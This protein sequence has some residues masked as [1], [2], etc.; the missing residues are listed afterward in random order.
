VFLALV[1]A[2][3][4]GNASAGNSPLG[5]VDTTTF[6]NTRV[7]NP[8]PV[9][10]PRH[11]ASPT[12]Q[13]QGPS[14]IVK[15]RVHSTGTRLLTTAVPTNPMLY[16][17]GR[18]LNSVSIYIDFWG[19][20]WQDPSQ[21]PVM[22]YIEGF[23]SDVGGSPWS[24][25]M[26]QYCSG[27]PLN[28]SSC[29]V[30]A[31]FVQN[32]VG[33]LK[34]A[35]INSNP[36][37]AAPTFS[38]IQSQASAVAAY[39]GYPSG[40]LFMV[41]TPSGKSESGFG[42]SFCAYHSF[43]QVGSSI[44][45]FAYMPYQPDAGYSCGANSVAGPLDGFSIVGVH[46]YSEAVTDPV[47]TTAP[48]YTGWVDPTIAGWQGE[49]GDKCAWIPAPEN[50][51]MNGHS[52]P[53]Q[54]LFS[55]QALAQGQSPCVFSTTTSTTVTSITP[56][57]GPTGGGTSVILTGTNFISVTAVSFG[58]NAATTYTVNSASQLVATSPPGT[59]TVDIIVTDAYGTNP[60]GLAD[61]FTYF[62]VPGA[63][64]NVTGVAG[65][66]QV[67]V[68]WTTPSSNGGNAIS[69][70]R[71]TSH[72]ALVA[73]T[74]IAVGL[75]SSLTVTGLT[76]G[77]TYTFTV[78]ALNAAGASAESTQSNSV[79]P[80]TL[81]GKPTDVRVGSV[82]G[83]SATVGWAAPIDDGGSPVLSYSVRCVPTCV[84]IVVGGASLQAV[85]TGLQAD[86]YITFRVTATNSV[87]VGLASDPSTPFSFRA[88]AVQSSPV[89][90]SG[91]PPVQQSSHP[92]SPTPRMLLEKTEEVRQTAIAPPL[93]LNST[94]PA[95]AGWPTWLTLLPRVIHLMRA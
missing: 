21:A 92:V 74:P 90:L 7:S 50:V 18:V 66:A 67:A 33:Q 71:V 15:A 86:T 39:Y 56:H 70:Y 28:S 95:D 34:G 64:T 51:V 26:G 29:P 55:N 35:V 32:P 46:E 88:S 44:L 3:V 59:G 60:M 2:P 58:S 14:R 49:I 69:G 19:T 79:T 87:G 1:P 82:G 4:L 25:T 62:G 31:T 8:V 47:P 5:V 78:A 83:G 77:T 57:Q 75:V 63:P 81:P 72:V 54:A 48:G 13:K 68:H 85:V 61:E 89:P 9:P 24:G 12:I 52:W 84:L 80:A 93:V 65:N 27:I 11:L 16:N 17:G 76:N 20:E 91:R 37:P 73:G 6:A 10:S 22:S 30:G 38:D 53:M 42:T 40:A 94:A 23:L 45:P 36:A 41:Y 43:V